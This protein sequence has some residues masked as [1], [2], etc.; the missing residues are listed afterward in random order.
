MSQMD[1]P[2]FQLTDLDLQVD[3]TMR[4]KNYTILF[5]D[6]RGN[7]EMTTKKPNLKLDYI[8][9]IVELGIV[10]DRMYDHKSYYCRFQYTT[11]Q[12]RYIKMDLTY[13]ATH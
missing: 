6:V 7:P 4:Y 8:N 10:S 2:T 12:L 9:K 1:R 13:T 5:T 3:Q 11:I